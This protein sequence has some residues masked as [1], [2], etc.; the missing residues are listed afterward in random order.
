MYQYSVG[1]A[2]FDFV[3]IVL[4]GIGLYFV[5]AT[6]SLWCDRWQ[7][8]AQVG[9]LLILC[10]GISKASWKLIVA[11]AQIDISWMNSALFVCLAP[12]MLIL[13]TVVWGA[14]GSKGASARQ[15]ALAIPATLIVGAVII[16]FIWPGQ[17][18]HTFY[19]LILT[20]IGNLALAT[21][22]IIKSWRLERLSASVMFFCNILAVFTLAGLARIPEQTEAL[23]WLEE[24]INAFSQAAFA[25][26]AYT[27]YSAVNMALSENANHGIATK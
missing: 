12:G 25:Y 15:L 11:T 18:Y 19:L 8:L 14:S 3:P 1:L 20:T 17:R 10:G 26:A 21:Q 16:A 23:Q 27:L 4:S 24:C 5:T 2:A 13:A 6:A 22:L 7:R 9:A